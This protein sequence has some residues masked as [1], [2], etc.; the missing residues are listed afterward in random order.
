MAGSALEGTEMEFVVRVS[1]AADEHVS[2]NWEVSEGTASAGE[3]YPLNQSDT[4]TIA[5]RRNGGGR[6]PCRTSEDSVGEGHETVEVSLRGAGFPDGVGLAGTVVEDGITDRATTLGLIVDPDGPSEDVPLFASASDE[7]RQGFLRVI[8]RGGRNVVHVV[9][10]DDG[11]N[12]RATTLEM[13][14]GETV[15]FNS[16]DLENGNIGKGLSRGVGEGEADWRLEL[17]GNDV[18]VLTY[19]RTN[20]GFLTSL[21]DD[22]PAG[23]GGYHVPI[24]N[25]GRNTNQESLLR[26]INPGDAHA[27]VTITGVDDQGA[28]SSGKASLTLAPGASRTISAAEPGRR[29]EPRGCDGHGYRQVASRGRVRGADSRLKPH[30]DPHGSPDESLHTSGQHGGGG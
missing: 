10:A 14:G 29:Y 8:N 21:H 2:V 6:S 15:H 18:D 17:S 16:N 7:T 4:F 23:T 12:R 22:V 24:F 13:D 30:A 28:E 5:A 25:P 19:M 20:D 26:L 9:A 1:P 27:I 3:D 11:G